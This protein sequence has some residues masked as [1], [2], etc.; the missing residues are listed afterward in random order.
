MEQRPLKLAQPRRAVCFSRR[1]RGAF[2]KLRVL[3]PQN[4]QGHHQQPAPSLDSVMR[5]SVYGCRFPANTFCE[6]VHPRGRVIS[7]LEKFLST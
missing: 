6:Q 1:S 5:F 2:S 4:W 7:H 3:E